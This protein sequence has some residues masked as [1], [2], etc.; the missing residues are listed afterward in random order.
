MVAITGTWSGRTAFFHS[1]VALL[2]LGCVD[3]PSA[4]G[5]HHREGRARRSD[6]SKVADVD[7]G[8]KCLVHEQCC[9]SGSR[10][11]VAPIPAATS[12]GVLSR[13]TSGERPMPR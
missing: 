5:R 7:S 10:A 8:R 1:Y 11:A 2:R 6:C 9:P 4:H 13:T 12:A 3:E